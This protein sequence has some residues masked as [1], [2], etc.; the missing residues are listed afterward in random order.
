MVTFG[1]LTS[2][3]VDQLLDVAMTW[4]LVLEAGLT[5]AGFLVILYSLHA[6]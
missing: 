1:V 4:V 6:E 2:G 5:A 3:V